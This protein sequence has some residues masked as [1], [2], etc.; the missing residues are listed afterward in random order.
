MALDAWSCRTPR[1]L[2]VRS[3]ARS[4]RIPSLALPQGKFFYFYI[5]KFHM[6]KKLTIKYISTLYL[7]KNKKK[8]HNKIYFHTVCIDY[9]RVEKKK[10]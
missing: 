7:N 8:V 6:L 10:R 9:D 5:Q 3:H 2:A 4:P 1:P